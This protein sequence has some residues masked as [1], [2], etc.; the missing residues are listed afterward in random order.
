MAVVAL[1]G[2]SR[3]GCG[4]DRERGFRQSNRQRRA[5][6]MLM[7]AQAVVCQGIGGA[8]KVSP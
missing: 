1:A 7:G 5:N 4:F 8:G 2:E 3:I 6:M